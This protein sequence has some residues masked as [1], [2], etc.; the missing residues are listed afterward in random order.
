MKMGRAPV[1]A[2]PWQS[3][4]SRLRR[5][6][7]V[8]T[9]DVIS[10]RRYV[11]NMIHSFKC[12]ET[13]R[14]FNGRFSARLPQSIQRLAARKLELLDGAGELDDL[15]SPPVNRLEVLGGDRAGQHSIRINDQWRICFLWRDGNALEVEIVDY[16]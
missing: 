9:L 6:L 8:L 2:R 16:H 15:K 4:L 14:L 10:G 11:S 12:K 3:F 7:F 1:G 13:Q 5:D